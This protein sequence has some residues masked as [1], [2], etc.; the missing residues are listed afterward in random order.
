M[1]ETLTADNVGDFRQRRVDQRVI[2]LPMAS[3]AE[4]QRL[5]GA[6]S[7]T[8]T[9]VNSD[10]G[11]TIKVKVS[12]TDD[13]G[14]SEEMTSAATESVTAAPASNSP[15]TGVPTHHWDGAGGRHADGGYLGYH[16]RGWPYQRFL[17]LPVDS[18]RREHRLRHRGRHKPPPTSY[19]IA[20]WARPSKYR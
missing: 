2:R 20:M 14:N 5:N 3:Q 8:Y 9:L 11:K 16:R 12:F 18:Q 4:T 1:G 10:E 15:A 7:S 13:A 19:P 17:R 6:T